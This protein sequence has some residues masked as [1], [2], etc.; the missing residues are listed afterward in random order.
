[1]Y[2]YDANT[3]VGSPQPVS[4]AAVATAV[5]LSGP[6]GATAIAAI[7]NQISGTESEDGAEAYVPVS[8]GTTTALVFDGAATTLDSSDT[9]DNGQ[10]RVVTESEDFQVAAGGILVLDAAGQASYTALVMEGTDDPANG[11]IYVENTAGQLIDVLTP[12]DLPRSS[13]GFVIAE[14]VTTTQAVTQDNGNQLPGSVETSFEVGSDQSYGGPTY[15]VSTQTGGGGGTAAPEPVGF[16]AASS[17][18]GLPFFDTQTAS[19]SAGLR[20][21]AYDAQG[22]SLATFDTGD[23]LPDLGHRIGADAAGDAVIDG[24]TLTQGGN[25]A[26]GGGN[27]LIGS[28]ELGQDLYGLSVLTGGGSL[29]SPEQPGGGIVAEEAGSTNAVDVTDSAWW[30]VNG[31]NDLI[32]LDNTGPAEFYFAQGAGDYTIA[33]D[34]AGDVTVTGGGTGTTTFRI[35]IGTGS[36]GEITFADG[37]ATILTIMS[38]WRFEPVAMRAA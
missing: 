15:T 38:L 36:G 8:V 24:V 23:E 16:T 3:N 18:Y 37:D 6:T 33:A 12:R 32:M 26:A 27:P 10:P 25:G 29:S 17:L 34:G 35:G 11:T 1:M 19:T 30:Q 21:A 22:G 31:S 13:G 7:N 4:Y 14:T 20:L 28:V 9:G 5:G 2:A